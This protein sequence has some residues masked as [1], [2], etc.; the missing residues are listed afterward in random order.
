MNEQTQTAILEKRED[1]ARLL[2]ISLRKL[3]L[4][5]EAKE[6]KV[7]RIGRRVLVPRKSLE[8]FCRK[9]TQ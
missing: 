4:L 3:E 5:I 2:G 6:L 9:N 7:V 1:A 8:D